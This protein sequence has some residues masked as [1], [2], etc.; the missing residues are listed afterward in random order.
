MNLKIKRIVFAI[1][2]IITF[3]AIFIFSGQNG[4]KSGN[5]SR[6]FT[7]R[8]I[9][10]LP[11]CR[12]LEEYK[13][14][15]IVENSQYIIRKLAHFTIYTLAGINMMGVASTYDINNRRKFANVL[16]VGTM[17]A[18]SDEIHQMFTGGRTP[19]ILDVGID[20]LGIFFGSLIVFSIS[21]V[22]KINKNN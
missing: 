12:D 17:Y 19:A 5:T 20:C 18:I 6:N 9:E 3:I 22:F 21:R 1:L 2:T 13:K 4:N 15:E 14:D 16:L 10:I 7:R 8:I 11:I